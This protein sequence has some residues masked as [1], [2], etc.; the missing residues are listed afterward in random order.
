[1][2]CAGIPGV[3]LHHRRNRAMGGSIR[4]DTNLPANA[5]HVCLPCHVW[6]GANPAQAYEKGWLVRQSAEP[7]LVP[8]FYR[9][10]WVKLDNV[11]GIRPME[12]AR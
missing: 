12:G 3:Q 7:A 2:V 4:P 5:L 10:D 9:G 6:I 8:V 11:G 1:V